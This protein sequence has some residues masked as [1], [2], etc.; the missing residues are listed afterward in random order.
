MDFSNTNTTLVSPLELLL[1]RQ[2]Q[3]DINKPFFSYMFQKHESAY[4][5]ANLL[6]KVLF[7][8]SSFDEGSKA[9]RDVVWKHM[10]AL[11]KI[12]FTSEDTLLSPIIS[13]WLDAPK[14]DLFTLEIF[15]I[16]F[17]LTTSCKDLCK[18]ANEEV[19]EDINL[20]LVTDPLDKVSIHLYF[21]AIQIVLQYS[22][23][24]VYFK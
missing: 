16:S 23:R 17:A 15:Y 6:H 5:F 24:I 21:Q 22:Y 8:A 7:Y 4:F 12:S 14:I 18:A 19:E 11:T 20:D 2:C 9:S 3:N 10:K 13:S 1:T